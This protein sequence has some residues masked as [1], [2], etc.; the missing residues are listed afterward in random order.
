MLD[1]AF[2]FIAE[3]EEPAPMI[4]TFYALDF[5]TLIILILASLL[6]RRRLYSRLRAKHFT[7][8]QRLSEPSLFSIRANPSILPANQFIWRREYLSL[9]DETLNRL[10][11]QVKILETLCYILIGFLFLLFTFAV[12]GSR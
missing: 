6:W 3:K 1:S 9:G 12:I 7:T 10:A 4:E 11:G 5:L 8:W 2:T